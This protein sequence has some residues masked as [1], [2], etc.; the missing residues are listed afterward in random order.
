MRRKRVILLSELEPLEKLRVRTRGAYDG[1][2]TEPGTV[3]SDGKVLFAGDG[4]VSSR[5]D[6]ASSFAEH[7]AADRQA[8]IPQEQAQRLLRGM[9]RRA[10]RKAEV[11][12][13]MKKPDWIAAADVDRIAVV[14]YGRGKRAGYLV[15][16]AHRLLLLRHLVAYDEI[17]CGGPKQGVVLHK[18][19]QPVGAMTALQIDPE[20]SP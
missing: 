11:L 2:V 7:R 8:I 1:T 18:A 15:L 17:R 4:V 13:Q 20:V 10:S 16:D 12:G 9:A 3:V 6:L 19:G 5:R 14:R